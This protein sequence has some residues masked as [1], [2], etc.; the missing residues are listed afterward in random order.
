MHVPDE[1][2]S[3]AGNVQV[4]MQ[5]DAEHLDRSEIHDVLRNDRRRMVLEQLAT[6]GGR[7]T[8]RELSERI[9]ERETD[10]TPAPRDVR[11]SVYVSLQQTH[12]PKLHD[13]GII[14]YDDSAQVVELDR[15]AEE[16]SVY[17][18]VVPTYGLSWAEY[19]AAVAVL[20]LLATLAS[21]IGVPAMVAVAPWTWATLALALVLVS[22]VYQATIQRSS[23]VHRLRGR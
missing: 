4:R 15:N 23:I 7:E 3:G 5:H 11:R 17:M 20:G 12:L 16:L 14:D 9:A 22:A 10:E 13:L 2:I 21:S 18:E 6:A 19:Y 1:R 8:L